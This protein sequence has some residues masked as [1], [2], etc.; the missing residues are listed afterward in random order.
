GSEA[1]PLLR[2]YMEDGRIV[3][4][5]PDEDE[6]RQYVLRQLGTAEL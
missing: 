5:L 3:E 2:K 4:R 1:R 6:I